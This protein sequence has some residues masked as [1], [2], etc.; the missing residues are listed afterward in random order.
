MPL[1]HTARNAM[2]IFR[3]QSLREERPG[4]IPWRALMDRLR[5]AVSPAT[6]RRLVGRR[7]AE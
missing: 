3:A 5:H 4:R 1:R 6:E 7:S 2:A